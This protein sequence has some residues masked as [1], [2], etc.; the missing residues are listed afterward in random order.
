[1]HRGQGTCLHLDI[2]SEQPLHMH[3]LLYM[4]LGF[5]CVSLDPEGEGGVWKWP[6][7]FWSMDWNVLLFG[8]GKLRILRMCLIVC[9]LSGVL[10]PSEHFTSWWNEHRLAS[11]LLLL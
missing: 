1:M 8:C 10:V 2:W 4:L 6:L 11:L 7:C 9:V 5:M 3:V